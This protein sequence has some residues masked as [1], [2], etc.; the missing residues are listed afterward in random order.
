[1]R[2]FTVAYIFL[3]VLLASGCIDEYMK[4]GNPVFFLMALA[5]T[6]IA[7]VIVTHRER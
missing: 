2:V 6:L 5:L 4:G 1:M 3:S 7:V